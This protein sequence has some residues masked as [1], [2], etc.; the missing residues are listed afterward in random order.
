MAKRRC[1]YGKE[2]GKGKLWVGGAKSVEG[3]GRVV[4]RDGM[5][6]AGLKRGF[7]KKETWVALLALG[8]V[9]QWSWG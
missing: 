2:A 7:A 8:R 3:A 9:G 1:A 5:V 4:W 6:L